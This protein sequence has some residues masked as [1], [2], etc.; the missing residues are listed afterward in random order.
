MS[1]EPPSKKPEVAREK[2]DGKYLGANGRHLQPFSSAESRPLQPMGSATAASLKK[3]QALGPQPSSR[4]FWKS[5]HQRGAMESQ[6]Q[7]LLHSLP[8]LPLLNQSDECDKKPES[9]Q[10]PSPLAPVSAKEFWE[11]TTCLG[12]RYRFRE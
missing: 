5:A 3:Q 7:T 10:P 2:S 1:D 6:M 4:L 8:P 12:A 9:E 11:E